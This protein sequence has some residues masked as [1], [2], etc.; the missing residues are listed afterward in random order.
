MDESSSGA[1][2]CRG[3]HYRAIEEEHPPFLAQS[4]ALLGDSLGDQFVFLRSTTPPSTANSR[5][6]SP[7]WA[8]GPRS[9]VDKDSQRKEAVW[10][11]VDEEDD[12]IVDVEAMCTACCD[13]Y[14]RELKL[15]VETLESEEIALATLLESTARSKIATENS[16]RSVLTDLE[17]KVQKIAKEWKDVSNEY[18][19]IRAERRKAE[20]ALADLDS[21]ADE[22]WSMYNELTFSAHEGAAT[23][24][25][26]Q[27]RKKY[28]QNRLRE[29]EGVS[30]SSDVFRFG[31]ADGGHG[32]TLPTIGGFRLGRSSHVKVA[33]EEIDAA[34]G[35]SALLL[36]TMSKCL[37][38]FVFT[39][40]RPIP[41]GA[42]SYMERLDDRKHFQLYRD[43]S[44]RWGSNGL[45]E[46]MVAFLRCLCEIGDHT[47]PA[48][49]LVEIMYL[50]FLATSTHCS[51]SAVLCGL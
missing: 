3:C 9:R 32:V 25:S 37:N 19:V 7:T 35:E 17:G 40:F 5:S 18:R 13:E 8:G 45:D 39:M 27:S 48:E 26:F 20:D 50:F 33:W 15:D 31:S 44:S 12:G 34:L 38:S 49:T 29:L 42:S 28:A 1:P 51:S 30:V 23:A 41:M 43:K 6:L 36:Y 4:N 21:E 2:L 16:L 11:L 14:L 46:G 47:W 22:Y 24:C 10:R